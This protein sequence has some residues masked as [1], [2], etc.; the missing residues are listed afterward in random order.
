MAKPPM[1]DLL[2][3]IPGITGSVLRRRGRDI[4]NLSASAA[5]SFL[6]TGGRSLRDLTLECDDPQADIADDIEATAL[7]ETAHIVPGLWKIDGYTALQK[8]LKAT[9]AIREVGAR[10]QQP[11]NFMTFPYD[12]R[13]D[14]R[15]SARLLGRAI[16][17]KLALWREAS[18]NKT[19]KA[20]VLAHS[21]GG[22]V[23]QYYI[24]CLRGWN[25]VR[26]L[27]TFGTPFRGA[28]Q[29][30][31]YI[32]HGYR[33]RKLGMTFVDL[34]DAM[35]SFPSV[36]QLLPRYPLINR[37]NQL[38]RV[39]DEYDSMGLSSKFANYAK[40]FHDE[41]DAATQQNSRDFQYNE[42]K[43]ATMPVVGTHQPT[44]QSVWRDADDWKIN[45][46]PFAGLAPSIAD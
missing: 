41:L 46:E 43:F 7:I 44:R 45:D 30:L 38:T 14:V 23:A 37:G 6:K 25:S 36:Y 28:P 42:A 32:L 16:D 27:V 33:A 34:T 35:R 15:I 39:F 20:I 2:V 31:E 26:A 22:L 17:R 8:M 24:E 13:R 11:G 4:W 9:F 1:S 40:D 12:W 21:M 5:L 3:L 19:A 29:A 10:D 18:G